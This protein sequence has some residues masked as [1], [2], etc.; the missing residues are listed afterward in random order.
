MRKRILVVGTGGSIAMHAAHSLDVIDYGRSGAV[1]SVADMLALVPEAA[2]IADLQTADFAAKASEAVGP[3]DWMEWARRLDAMLRGHAAPDGVV[4]VHGTSNLEETAW[5]LDLAL[6]QGMPIVATGA[7]RPFGTV[8]SDAGRNL[9]DAIRVAA[10]PAAV[11]QG[12]LVVANGEIHGARDV[13][14]TST[15][16]LN[17][18]Q[19]GPR[20]PLGS[21]D[22]DGAVRIAS[23]SRRHEA[24]FD[25]SG[26]VELPRTDIV[27]A[28]AGAD[29]CATDALTAAGS[30]GIVVAGLA[31][32][33]CAP[34]QW[35][36]LARSAAKGVAI[37]ICSRAGHGRVLATQAM[38]E[39]GFI[40]GND[41]TPQKARILLMLCLASGDGY[42]QIHRR[43]AE[44]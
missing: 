17:A 42:A 36:A 21:V 37:V 1:L 12:V 35:A 26:A 27:I 28:Y 34:D 32:G 15:Y 8:G 3:A 23:A 44:V 38:R 14:K 24:R 22:A 4:I 11:G 7:M 41:L 20:S 29:G 13:T 19:S 31:P 43:F 9:L 2:E 30:R 39:Q 40:A 10:T 6:A 16:A 5:F 18:F 25:L 33:T